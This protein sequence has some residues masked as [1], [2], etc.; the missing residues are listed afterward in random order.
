MDN[1]TIIQ[2][3]PPRPSM[4][5]RI[6]IGVEGIRAGWSIGIFILVMSGCT[7]VFFIPTHFYLARYTFPAGVLDPLQSGLSELAAFL[8]LLAGTIIMT[9]IEHKP[10]ISYG[11]DGSRRFVLFLYGLICG[12][13]ALTLLVGLLMM[14]GLLHLDGIQIGGM[15]AIKYGID[16]GIVFLLVGLYE[17]YLM[18]GYLQATLTRGIGFWWGAIILSTLFGCAHISNTGESPVGIFSA[19][20]V[21]LVF[22]ISLW[23]LKTLWWA[24][25]FHAAWDWAQSYFWGTADSGLLA[26][27]HL[28]GVHPQGNIIWSGGATGPEGSLL[29]IPLL[30]IVALFMWLAWHSKKTIAAEGEAEAPSA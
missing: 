4:M 15:A 25:G 29:V 28:F 24:I 21:G 6:F 20:L 27:G 5:H 7:V 12:L 19:A 10:L 1:D 3:E 8:G 22:C 17:E 9:R 13:V 18:R 26:K 2:P 23:Y 14:F 11:L 16:W 30:L